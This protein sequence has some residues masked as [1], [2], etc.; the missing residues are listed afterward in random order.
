MKTRIALFSATLL[1]ALC[2]PLYAQHDERTY[3]SI[4]EMPDL[5]KIL[6]AP[7]DTTG[8]DF[9]NDISRYMW[10]KTQRLNPERAAIAI[11]DAAWQNEDVFKEYSIPFGLTLS[12]EGTPAIWEV[13]DRG[14]STI[15]LIRIRP[16]AFYMRKRPFMRFNEH[17][18]SS[19]EEENLRTDGSYPSGH[20]I[21]NWSIALI[22]AQINPAAADT[23]FKR[24][25]MAGESRVIVGAHW[26][27]DV[28]AGYLAASIGFA[29]LQSS[30][31]FQAQMA[32]AQREF[33]ILTGQEPRPAPE[34]PR[35]RSRQAP[36]N[37]S[38]R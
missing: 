34:R 7:P 25:Y 4:D 35:R 28:N 22:L 8:N 30:P 6:P 38:V 5:I 24:A 15:G 11:R 20:T 26:Q 12:K 29:K 23:L 32:A 17:M 13:L 3:F 19:W 31:E 1:L 27:S 33:R 16:K 21:K 2:A 18:L 14:V 9:I 36:R 37:Y 10:G